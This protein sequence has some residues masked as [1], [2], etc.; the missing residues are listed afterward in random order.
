MDKEPRSLHMDLRQLFDRLD[1]ERNLRRLHMAIML[2]HGA[3]VVAHGAA[4]LAAL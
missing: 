3:I 2:I 4:M 1:T